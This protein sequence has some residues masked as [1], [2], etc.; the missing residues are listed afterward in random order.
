LAQGLLAGRYAISG[1][2]GRGA[3]GRVL[4]AL[5][6]AEG[7]APRAIKLVGREQEARL[8]WELGVLGSIAHPNLARVYELLR[9]DRPSSSPELP[10]GSVALVTELAPGRPADAWARE[11]RRDSAGLLALSVVVA[12]GVAR[13]LRALHERGLLHG[14]VKPANIVVSDDLKSCKLI[15]LGL[16]VELGQGGA[17]GGT[18][19]YLAPELWR[20]ERGPAADLY[21]LGVTLDRLLRGA[22]DAAA[23]TTSA[24]TALRDALTPSAARA[25]LPEPVP[26]ALRRLIESLIEP[27]PEVR[28]QHAGEVSARVALIAHDCGQALASSVG[29]GADDAP[30]A[31]EKALA[32]SA[33]AFV[34]HDAALDAL[35][36][37]LAQPGLCVVSGPGGAGRSRLVREAVRRLQSSRLAAGLPVPTY[38]TCP[39]LPA[40]ALGSDSVLH[41][42]DADAVTSAEAAALLRAAAVEGCQLWLVLERMRP[43][44]PRAGAEIA[45]HPLAEGELRRLLEQALP[46]VRV[47]A[48]HVREALAVSGGLSGLLCRILAQS[49]ASGADM[50]RAQSLR[51]RGT[52]LHDGA[53]AALS[54]PARE[55]LELLAI[56][57]GELAPAAAQAALGSP[58]HLTEAY[59]ALLSAGLASR[60]GERLCLRADTIAL[61]RDALSPARLV[62][63]AARLP[64][65]E[66]DGRARA[67]LWLAR[68]ERTRAR[69]AFVEEIAR[70]RAQGRA[71][72]AALCA[73]EALRAIGDLDLDHTLLLQLADALRAQGRYPE[74][75]EALAVADTADALA[76]RAEL[77]RLCGDREPALALAERARGAAG[78]EPSTLVAAEAILAR[79]SYDQGD[80]ERAERLAEAASARGGKETA[81]LRAQEVLALA[82]LHRG[83]RERAARLLHA[84][85]EIAQKVRLREPEARLTSLLAQVAREEGDPHGAARRYAQAFELADAAGEQ[86]AAAAFLH[87]VGIERL[88]CGEPGPAIAALRESAR[89]LARLG[90]DADLG[91]VLYN[92]GHAAQLIGHDDVALPAAQR[93]REAASRAG[94]RVTEAYA[95]CI[96]A[97]L[98][99]KQGERKA[100]ASLL[101]QPLDLAGLA[102][103]AVATIAARCVALHLGLGEIELAQQRLE[104]AERAANASQSEAAEIEHAIA[105]CQLELELGHGD[106]ARRAAEHAHGLSQR[107]GSF[108]AR[109]RACLCAAR[110]ARAAGDAGLSA[111]RLAEVRSMLDQAARSLSASERTRLRAVDVYRAAFEALPS[112]SV[113][114]ASPVHDERWRTLAGVAKRLTAERR[115]PRLHEIV[116]DAAIELGGAERGYLVLKDHDGLPR[117][118]AGR[119]L[120]RR[121]VAADEQSLSRSIVARVL[122][123]ARPLTTMDAASDV[124]LS[125][126]ASVHALSLRSVL[127]VPLCIGGEVVGA[128]Y[129]E[130]RLRPF[131]FGDL[132][133]AL[134]SDLAELAAIALD[135]ARSLR[136]ERRAARRL[137]VLRAR[138]A[139]RVEAQ[140]LELEALKRVRSD[141]S[142]SLPG[143]IGHSQAM[144]RVLGMVGKVA[145]SPVPV[146][147]CGES[148]TGKELI[149]QAIHA[150][151]SRRTAAFVSENCGAIP[152][153]LLESALFGHVRGA[154]TGADRRRLGLFEVAD[155]GTLLLDEIGEM[156]PAMQA[157]LLRVLQDGEVRPVGGERVHRVDVR[158]LAAT[159]RD[160]EAMVADGSFRED[161]YYRL[162]VMTLRLPPLRERPE[163]IPPLLAHLI[164]K[165]AKGRVLEIDKRALAALTAHP[166]PGNVRQLENE[167][168]RALV[169]A[170]SIIMPEHLSPGLLAALPS[171]ASDPLDLRAQVDQ[172]ERKLIRQ[173]LEA[174]AGNQTRAARILGVSRY[175]L[176]K[177][178]RRLELGDEDSLN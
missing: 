22:P 32:V 100:A 133:L 125:G 176:Q 156:S 41:I 70:L 118:S 150:A 101:S 19:G 18:P 99:L 121:D 27:D 136:A 67:H 81:S 17:L 48:P 129:L 82:L 38:R 21:A 24:A 16:A 143:I 44:E 131:A 120:D 109:L 8:R 137:T 56:A 30:S 50:A 6:A 90:R 83:Q 86:H 132:E 57:G 36:L 61:Q 144:Q 124:E 87:N 76:L 110:A 123:S 34:G 161:L 85:L 74:A 88:D 92:L 107:G 103:V 162:A 4:L 178:I 11:L 14:D 52:G 165:H 58:E 106:E 53:F 158:V 160:L 98:R 46:G 157:R 142:S 12:D 126:A 111:V 77:S 94:D 43:L 170:D 51:G 96:E 29:G 15:D 89:R 167:V 10:E 2:L 138:L 39:R 84:A 128:I 28:I 65:A 154:F 60:M 104:Q 63:R 117:V 115:A 114:A 168:R 7:D 105:R 140:A 23:H 113:G 91:R 42:D 177:M 149:A 152:E 173:A 54:E 108:D 66:L 119:G 64:E 164:D 9:V 163:D 75:L 71:E 55:L 78:E 5:D 49:I 130:D 45:L 172:L 73:R 26:A 68:G 146:L 79:L 35:A 147:I 95:R 93:A 116:L 175:G 59:R 159:H 31:A 169:L 25:P 47:T 72:Q 134:L 20:G 171:T 122:G 80:I 174:A 166:W 69:A 40:G 145:R 97:E 3:S 127:A 62:E 1:E 112:K 13:A 139:R 135:S 155:G 102:D 33:L 148:G 151:S 37:A 153:P 141:E